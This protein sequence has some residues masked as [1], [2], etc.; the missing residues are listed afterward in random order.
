MAFTRAPLHLL[1]SLG[2]ALLIRA[3]SVAA[4]IETEVCVY[5]ATS[6][7]V[8]AAVQAAGQGKTVALASFNNHIGGTTS[9]GLGA[10]DIGNSGAIQGV[11]REFYE[12]VAIRY[13]QTGAKFTF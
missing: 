5:G 1:I 6:G 4:V 7:G 12:R 11:S 9:G 10:T 3:G 8:I 2:L 13:G